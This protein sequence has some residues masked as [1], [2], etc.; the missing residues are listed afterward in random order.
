M[1]FLQWLLKNHL[2]P[3]KCNCSIR[4]VNSV[5]EEKKKQTSSTIPSKHQGTLISKNMAIRSLSPTI[6]FHANVFKSAWNL[7]L[8]TEY[9]KML[10]I[11]NPPTWI[12]QTA[13]CYDIL[14]ELKLAINFPSA[15]R[16]NREPARTTGRKQ[17]WDQKQASFSSLN[18]QCCS[19]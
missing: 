17:R 4:A 3:I 10:K 2:F 16:L 14:F 8:P 7:P 6:S 12:M 1:D 19:L 5:L 15:C 18:T 11:I 13:D 9:N